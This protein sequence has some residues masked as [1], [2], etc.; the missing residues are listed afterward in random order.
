MILSLQ[1]HAETPSKGELNS[2]LEHCTFIIDEKD[3]ELEDLRYNLLKAEEK[4][5]QKE[6]V[7]KDIRRKSMHFPGLRLSF[8]EEDGDQSFS[9]PF[10]EDDLKKIK[11]LEQELLEREN[12]LQSTNSELKDTQEKLASLTIE[13]ETLRGDCLQLIKVIFVANF[14]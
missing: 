14:M 9:E 7:I 10:R 2:K 1:P 3:V 12:K 6:N 5:N 8:P 4:I 11:M 13:L